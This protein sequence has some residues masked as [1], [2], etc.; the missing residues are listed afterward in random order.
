MFRY[1]DQA[2]I[3]AHVASSAMA[4]FQKEVKGADL[5]EKPMEL[6]FLSTVGGFTSKL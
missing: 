4:A 3:D 6:K 2:A 5:L 1:K